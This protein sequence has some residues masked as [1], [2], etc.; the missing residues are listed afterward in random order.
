[1]RTFGRL[2]L[3]ETYTGLEKSDHINTGN[4]VYYGNEGKR[5]AARAAYQH[6]SP[7]E[8]PGLIFILQTE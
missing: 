8:K 5:A 4:S 6:Y 1:M 3:E 7:L 2:N